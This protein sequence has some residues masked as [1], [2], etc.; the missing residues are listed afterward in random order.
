MQMVSVERAATGP[1]EPDPCED[2]YCEEKCQEVHAAMPELAI[3]MQ[4]DDNIQAADPQEF[5]V[6]WGGS[7]LV[8]TGSAELEAKRARKDKRLIYLDSNKINAAKGAA[9]MR[10]S[11]DCWYFL[12]MLG[13][14]LHDHYNSSPSKNE[15]ENDLSSI[16]RT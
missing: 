3:S 14:V 5:T 1:E 6:F 16:K 13:I 7:I 8:D 10:Y 15:A 12:D 2:Q 9:N 4:V 11:E